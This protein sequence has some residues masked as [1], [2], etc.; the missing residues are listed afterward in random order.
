MKN[1]ND[2]TATRV[3]CAILFLT[4]TYVF[5]RYY[6]GDMLVVEQ[7]IASGGKTHY[8]Y[9]IGA[10]LLTLFLFLIQV[11]AAALTRLRGIFHAVTYFPSLLIL[12]FLVDTPSM[13]RVVEGGHS[14]MWQLPLLLALWGGAV[15]IARRYQRVE[16]ET[17][18]GGLLSQ[19][20]FIN[21]LVLL[22]FMLMPC[23][24]GNADK[25]F[26]QR[27]KQEFLITHGRYAEALKL[28]RKAEVQ[29]H[30]QLMLNAYCLYRQGNLPD[31]LFYLSVP[32]CQITLLP[33]TENG[34]FLLLADSTIKKDYAS[35]RDVLLCNRLVARQV[36]QFMHRMSLWYKRRNNLPLHFREAIAL[37]RELHTPEA[38]QFPCEPMD[39]A[40]MDFQR[41]RLNKIQDTLRTK[42][43][44]T[45]WYYYYRNTLADK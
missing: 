34:S 24:M 7:H 15:I 17:R 32:H 35:M 18:H 1:V 11:G 43:G 30:H 12:T 14:W 21:V 20:T 5:L 16:A 10:V 42:Y 31:S 41:L 27:V 29:D 3:V 38:E 22:T 37:G 13:E 8:E 26:H 25:E 19:L 28:G 4:F 33:G 6:E 23:L 9:L 39:T 2:S 45:Y 40:L 36:P 44:H